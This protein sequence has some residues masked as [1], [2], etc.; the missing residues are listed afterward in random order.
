MPDSSLTKF[1]KNISNMT[2]LNSLD[3]DFRFS[4]ISYFNQFD[5]LMQVSTRFRKIVLKN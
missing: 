3:L 4:I 5:L 1:V 2:F